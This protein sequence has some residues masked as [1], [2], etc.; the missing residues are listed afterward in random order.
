MGACFSKKNNEVS[1]S[2]SLKA[3]AAPAS[4][5]VLNHPHHTNNAT[6]KVD[7]KNEITIKNKILEQK[8]VVTKQVVEEEEEEDSLLKKEIFVIKHRKSHDRDK[9]IPPPNDDGPRGP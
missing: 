6:L 3:A 1:S 9:R 4:Q 7:Q 2:P 8:E 5:P